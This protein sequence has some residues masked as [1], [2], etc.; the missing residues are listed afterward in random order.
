MQK[1]YTHLCH[2]LILKY[3]VVINLIDDF[4]CDGCTYRFKL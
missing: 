3:A 4:K 1:G 2:G